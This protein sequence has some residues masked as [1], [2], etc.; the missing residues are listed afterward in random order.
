MSVSVGEDRCAQTA[1]TH[2]HGGLHTLIWASAVGQHMLLHT[3]NSPDEAHYDD[4]DYPFNAAITAL[5]W[6]RG[7]PNVQ[8]YD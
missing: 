1:P 2:G 6:A 7:F 3:W 4:L 5:P 8:L